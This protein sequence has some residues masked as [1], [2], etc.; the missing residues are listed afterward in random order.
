MKHPEMTPDHEQLIKLIVQQLSMCGFGEDKIFVKPGSFLADD[1]AVHSVS[2]DVTFLPFACD[3]G[4]VAPPTVSLLFEKVL[5]DD[6]AV[7]HEWQLINEDNSTP[8][9]ITY[10][11]LFAALFFQSQP[12]EQP[13]PSV[14]DE[15]EIPED[16]AN[17][18]IESFRDKTLLALVKRNGGVLRVN[19]EEIDSCV[20]GFTMALEEHSMV[21][22]AEGINN[23]IPTITDENDLLRSA[24]QIAKRNGVMTNWPAF[25]NRLRTFLVRA[26]GANAGDPAQVEGATCTMKTFKA[27]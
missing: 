20:G 22:V 19:F 10:G 12:V 3:D 7:P 16:A 6:P 24:Y 15:S 25:E 4:I 27:H 21:L 5:D 11:N 9:P 23:A 26:A 13:M 8:T 2:I 1:D 17:A 18:V 14:E